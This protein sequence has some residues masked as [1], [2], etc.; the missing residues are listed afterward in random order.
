MLTKLFKAI[1]NKDSVAFTSFL[2][3]DCCFR[4]GNL[5]EVRGTADIQGFVAGFFGSILALSHRIEEY[6]DIP[7]GLVCHGKVTYTRL[8][9]ST[10]T[11][12]FANIFKRDVDGIRDYAIYAD[13]S[14][15]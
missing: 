14:A 3:P 10:L 7:D 12:P 1:D 5:P 11:V 15:L 13:T 8:D 4:F 6:W 2:S 9:G